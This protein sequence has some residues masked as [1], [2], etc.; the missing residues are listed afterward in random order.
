M[1]NDIEAIVSNPIGQPMATVRR[2]SSPLYYLL[3][4]L[5][6]SL[7]LLRPT[8]DPRRLVHC[9][10]RPVSVFS[11]GDHHASDVNALAGSSWDLIWYVVHTRL[12]TMTDKTKTRRQRVRARSLPFPGTAVYHFPGISIASTP[13]P[14][15]LSTACGSRASY[16]CC[17]AS[18]PLL[19]PSRLALSFR[20]S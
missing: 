5:P 6:D 9:R 12:N 20:L 16:P 4:D 15:H 17:S 18:W 7:Q 14:R 11:L 8:W 1:G 13:T 2:I 10:I 19:D 3:K